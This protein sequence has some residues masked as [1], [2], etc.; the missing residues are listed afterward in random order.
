MVT[1]FDLEALEALVI[2]Q[3]INLRHLG[4]QAPFPCRNYCKEIL[5]CD[6]DECL[7]T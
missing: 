6:M 3:P 7:L 5:K 4:F 2:R 1:S